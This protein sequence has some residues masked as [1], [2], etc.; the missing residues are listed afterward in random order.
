MS[1]FRCSQRTLQSMK[2]AKDIC[3]H[4]FR[5]LH[6]TQ[7]PSASMLSANHPGVG[8][9]ESIVSARTHVLCTSRYTAAWTRTRGGRTWK[10]GAHVIV[11]LSNGT[12]ILDLLFVRH[13][14]VTQYH[15]L[16][17]LCSGPKQATCRRSARSALLSRVPK[18]PA[19][20]LLL[21]RVRVC[22]PEQT[23]GRLC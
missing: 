23:S 7:V 1:G 20:L 12:R 15:T 2:A 13:M 10:N 9:S 11:N 18:Q 19:S 22:V 17:C 8:A 14:G 16:T 5:K 3:M 6:R 4:R 21:S